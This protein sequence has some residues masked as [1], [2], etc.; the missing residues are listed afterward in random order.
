MLDM[1]WRE[2]GL[3]SMGSL[4]IT[5]STPNQKAN[6]SDGRQL[7]LGQNLTLELWCYVDDSHEQAKHALQPVFEA[8]V[9]CAAPLGMLRYR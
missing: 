5:G 2:M 4:P 1:S 7:Q 8:H 3:A 6:A 9:E